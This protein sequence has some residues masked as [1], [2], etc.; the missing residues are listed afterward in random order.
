M[1]INKAY[2]ALEQT[3]RIHHTSVERIIQEIDATI[4][5]AIETKN[6]DTQSLRKAIPSVS[7]RPSAVELIAYLGELSGS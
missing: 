3:A 7:K 1:D 6:A 2:Q 5:E 4:A